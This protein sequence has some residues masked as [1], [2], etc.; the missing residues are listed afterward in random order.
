[1]NRRDAS[2]QPFI[3]LVDE[4]GDPSAFAVGN[5]RIIH[6][7]PLGDV[8]GMPLRRRHVRPIPPEMLRRIY[9]EDQSL[10]RRVVADL[11]TWREAIVPVMLGVA[12]AV[13]VGALIA[14]LQAKGWIAR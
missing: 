2:E 7:F 11:P 8:V 13:L 4:N 9:D 3:R 10:N 5:P 14:Y 6:A 12:L 1:V